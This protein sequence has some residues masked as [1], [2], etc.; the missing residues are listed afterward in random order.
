MKQSCKSKVKTM[1]V[2]NIVKKLNCRQ[3]GTLIAEH[4]EPITHSIPMGNKN[5]EATGYKH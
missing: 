4:T 2:K 3:G 1:I 5:Q